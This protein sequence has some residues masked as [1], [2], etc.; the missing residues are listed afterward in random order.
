[1][2]LTSDAHSLTG[3]VREQNEDLL[4][5]DDS[6]GL[7]IVCDG[8]GGHAGG[9]IASRTALDLVASEVI[10]WCRSYPPSNETPES[11]ETTE[12]IKKAFQRA[13]DRLKLVGKERPELNGMGTTMTL[14][15]IRNGVAVM[16][17]IG[18][19]RLYLQRGGE[20]RQL[21]R[22]HTYVHEMVRRSMMTQEEAA[23]SPYAHMLCRAL[24]PLETV[25]VDTLH[26]EVLDGDSFLLCSDGIHG[27][28]L[29]E[30]EIAYVLAKNSATA[31]AHDLVERAN[32]AD[33]S[34]NITAV[35][36]S[37]RA[38]EER[39]DAERAR[40]KDLHLRMETLQSL[41]MFQGLAPEEMLKVW[42][43][44]RVMDYANNETII[45]EGE[46]GLALYIVLDGAVKV[47]RGDKVLATLT[48]GSHFGEMALLRNEPR[49]ASV[50]SLN[51]ARLIAIQGRDFLRLLHQEHLLGLKLMWNISVK[52]SDRLAELTA[53]KVDS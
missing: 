3:K 32:E 28:A 40:S 21:S 38:T 12:V 23:A 8:M 19:S 5:A 33:G 52:L 2:Q 41:Y 48:Q 20:L 31:P 14:L 24:G 22:D 11:F 47:T 10:A 44:A 17:H 53:Q 51:N 45:K 7:Y 25:E 46:D 34:D 30:R 39:K 13:N 26:F 29:K 35:T 27:G 37:V 6:H 49:M 36:V 15:L 18:D 4:F 43:I 1:M 16:A 42:E 50:V 9:A